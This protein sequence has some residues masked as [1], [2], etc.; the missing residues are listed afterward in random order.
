M[1]GRQRQADLCEFESSLVYRVSFR[2]GSKATQRNP[3]SE[4]K[5]MKANLHTNDIDVLDI[6]IIVCRTSSVFFSGLSWL[7]TTSS[8]SYSP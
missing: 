2:I 6:D 7:L 4:K 1:L 3:V 8:L 5:K